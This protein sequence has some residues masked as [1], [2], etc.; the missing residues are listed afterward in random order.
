MTVVTCKHSKKILPLSKKVNTFLSLDSHVRKVLSINSYIFLWWWLCPC[1]V[2]GDLLE[3]LVP[4]KCPY[5]EAN[6][7]TTRNL[8]RA[9]HF[10]TA[11]VQKIPRPQMPQR[12]AP[13]G[14]NR[15]RYSQHSLSHYRG[16]CCCSAAAAAAAAESA[17]AGSASS[18]SP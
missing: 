1:A 8:G 13:C 12:L 2:G 18:F 15:C 4:A 3:K 7:R 14:H 16:R 10:A 6:R 5:P 17:Q 11:P 9:A